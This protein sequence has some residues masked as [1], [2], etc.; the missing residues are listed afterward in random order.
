L[1]PKT[2][3]MKAGPDGVAISGESGG[4]STTKPVPVAFNNAI[5]KTANQGAAWAGRDIVGGDQS[6]VAIA[7]AVINLPP[8]PV[9]GKISQL[10]ARLKV[11]VASNQE[12][13]A[14]LAELEFYYLHRAGDGVQGLEAKLTASGQQ[15]V[16]YWAL[17]QKEQFAK[18]LERWSLYASAQEILAH[19]LSKAYYEF[20]VHILPRLGDLTAAEITTIFDERFVQ[21]TVEECGA[22]V[23]PMNHNIAVGMVYWLAEQ[24]FVR[25]HR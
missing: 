16:I 24:C 3:Q 5:T 13:A 1:T 8:Q 9:G 17:E 22:G 7:N 10:L 20:G 11:E 2:T 6:K 4:A 25:W 18:T 14:R 21:P 19:F 15:A 12:V 23:L